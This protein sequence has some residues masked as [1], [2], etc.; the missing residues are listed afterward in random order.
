MGR[1]ARFIPVG[2][3][4]AEQL[5]LQSSVK[6]VEGGQCDVGPRGHARLKDAKGLPLHPLPPLGPNPRDDLW[7]L[8]P[9]GFC[10]AKR[11]G[12]PTNDILIRQHLCVCVS[13]HVRPTVMVHF[14][15]YTL[16]VEG[17]GM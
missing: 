4:Q 9:V 16:N 17:E 6:D 3:G 7:N 8:L 15:H 11:E 14:R 12:L 1:A 2:N 5:G 10:Y 13:M